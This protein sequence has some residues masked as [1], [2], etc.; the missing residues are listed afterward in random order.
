MGEQTKDA[1][2]DDVYSMLFHTLQTTNTHMIC[3]G[4]IF[5]YDDIERIRRLVLGDRAVLDSSSSSLGGGVGLSFM[6]ARA[7]LWAPSVFRD[8]KV[9][10]GVE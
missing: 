1:A 7:A 8:C 5:C 3:N 10:G 2:H 9:S 4:D 6:L